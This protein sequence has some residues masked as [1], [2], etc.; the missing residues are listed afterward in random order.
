METGS[1]FIKKG[2]VYHPSSA[3]GGQALSAVAGLG[4][5]PILGGELLDL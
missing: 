1:F 4:A 5:P 2:E 3:Y